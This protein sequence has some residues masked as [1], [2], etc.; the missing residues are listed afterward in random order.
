MGQTQRGPISRTKTQNHKGV[1]LFAVWG[2]A[3]SVVT[4]SSIILLSWDQADGL[5]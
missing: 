1:G 2:I 5:A 4:P 3:Q